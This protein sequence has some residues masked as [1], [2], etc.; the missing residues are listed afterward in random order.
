MRAALAGAERVV[1]V[2]KAFAVGAGGIVGQN[3]RLALSGL[4]RE[5]HDVVA[6]LGG[7]PITKASLHGLL[8]DAVA[9]RLDRG[10]TFLD[11]DRE[12]VE[13]EL[14]APATWPGRARTPRA[15]CARSAPSPRGRSDGRTRDQVLPD[16]QL[17]RRRPAARPAAA[18]RA[19]G[20]RR[21]NT[22][23]CGHRACQGCGEA[24]GARYALDAAMRA[25]GGRLIA[26]NATGCLEVFSTPYPRARGSC[27]GSTRCS[28]TRPPS[29]PG[30]PPR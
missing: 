13:R 23:T 7:R 16:R 29:R 12:L 6:G 14:R 2:E 15:S 22:L 11:L 17:R 5:V 3:V 30:S 27:P 18:H 19:V 9:D 25:S 21:S 4:P 10:L 24:L 26:A 28:A 1:V 20:H 8:V